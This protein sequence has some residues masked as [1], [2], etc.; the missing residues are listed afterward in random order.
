MQLNLDYVVR[1]IRQKEE[2]R[3]EKKRCDVAVGADRK[4][5]KCNRGLIIERS[6]TLKISIT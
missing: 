4:R 6:N 5:Y 1:T 3:E 2:R